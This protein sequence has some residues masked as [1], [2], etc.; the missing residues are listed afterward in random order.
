MPA[1]IVLICLDKSAERMGLF[2]WNVCDSA[3]VAAFYADVEISKSCANWFALLLDRG[4]FASAENK[5]SEGVNFVNTAELVQ[6][7]LQN[8]VNSSI[9]FLRL[10]N[11]M[12]A[13]ELRKKGI[14]SSHQG[15]WYFVIAYFLHVNAAGHARPIS[16]RNIFNFPGNLPHFAVN[17]S[18]IP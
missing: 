3:W 10:A 8:I 17:G 7:L 5:D 13:A 15:Y 6:G 11:G 2:Y 18:H 16:K 14:H 9:L 1:N 4:N 12:I